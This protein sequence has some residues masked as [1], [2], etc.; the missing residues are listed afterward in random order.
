[1]GRKR[2]PSTNDFFGGD[3]WSGVGKTEFVAY[4]YDGMGLVRC[5]VMCK[6]ESARFDDWPSIGFWEAV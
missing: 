5:F 2:V 6:G 3:T 4:Q 1:M